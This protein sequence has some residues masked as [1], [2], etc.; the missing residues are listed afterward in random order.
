M[1]SFK[2]I[3]SRLVLAVLLAGSA[4][5]ASAKSILV[6][7]PHP[8]DETMVS[9]GRTRA[10]VLAGDTVHIVLS[11]NGDI[12]GRSAG[13]MREAESV[14]AAAVLGVPE[15]SVIFLGYGDQLLYNVWESASGT[16]VIR[17]VAGQTATYANRGLGG[18][19]FHSWRTGSPGPYNRN[20]VM[21]DFKA[22]ITAFQPDE[23]YT[24]SYWDNHGDHAA[25]AFFIN[26]ALIA[27]KQQGLDIRTRVFQSM[28]WPPDTGNNCYANWP[29][30]GSGALPYPPYPVPPCVVPGTT[31]DWNAVQRFAVPP[32][33]QRPDSATNLKWQALAAYPSQ[34]NDFLSSFVRE[35]EFFWR[36]DYGTN[37]SALAQVSASTDFPDGEGAMAHAIDGYADL[38]HEWKSQ[39][40]NGA[41]IQLNWSSPVRTAQINLYDRLDVNDNVRAGTLS[42]SDGSTMSVGA[43]PTGGKPLSVTFSPRVVSWVRFTI[44]QAVGNTAGLAEFEVLGVPASRTD[45]VAPHI[46]TGPLPA[47]ATIDSSQTLALS[48]NAWD[49][50]GD[51]LAYSWSADGGS[52]AGNGPSA[53]YT[54]PA[55]S[56]TTLFTVS[57]EISDGRGGVTGNSA[58][59]TVT[60]GR[61]AGLNLSPAS[62]TAGL[63]ST[64]TVLLSSAAP[65]GGTVVP[66]SSSNTAAAQAP[67][68]VTVSAGASSATFTISTSPVSATTQVVITAT[69]GGQN[70]TANLTVTPAGPTGLTLVPA[71]AIG[72][73]NVQATV[74]VSTA[75]PPGGQVLDLAASNPSLVSMPATV[76]VPAGSTTASF[77]IATSPVASAQTLSVTA[78]NAGV[79]VSATLTLNPL[80]LTGLSLNPASVAGGVS[81]QGT[82]TM[83]GPAYDSSAVV[84]LS[85]SNGAASV[86]ASV[87][88]AAGSSTA[89]F[90]ATTVS[91]GAS[92]SSTIT[93]T[94][95]GT[96]RTAVLTVNPPALSAVSLSPATVTAGA[97]STGT[98]TLTGPAPAAGLPVALSSNTPAA[99]S[100]PA[101][102]TVP[103]GTSSATFP[104]TTYPVTAKK[105]VTISAV[106]AGVT[107]TATL[108]VNTLTVSTI[109]LAPTSLIG[110]LASIATV[111]MSGAVPDPGAQIALSSGTAAAQVPASV[112]IPA[113][114]TTAT[115]TVTTSAVA[116]STSAVISATYG[117]TKTATLTVKP[118]A[119]SKL[120]LAPT[121]LVGGATSTATITLTGPAPQ[122]GFAVSTASN[123][124]AAVVPETVV[125]PEGALTADFAVATSA[126]AAVTSVSISSTAGT[127]T[128]SATLVITPR[129]AVSSIVLSPASVGSGGASVA[130]VT[131][132]APAP[133]GGLSVT[134]RSSNT[135][136]A[137]VPASVLVPEGATSATFSVLAKTVTVSS[138]ASI[139]AAAGG[140]TKSATLTVTP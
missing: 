91:V 134:T 75:A 18:T 86:P 135:A 38:S 87:T 116:A 103:G 17:S 63:T 70:K 111:T 24:V 129:T 122:G 26:E 14:A 90:T 97:G 34:F 136:V 132:N 50:D 35:D 60:P 44:D 49:L 53:V 32:E 112:T 128:K 114:A 29:P 96:S 58:F 89:T 79:T 7:G 1:T 67:A 93:A 33:M 80:L 61:A 5:P 47:V 82:V 68:S 121:S 15:Q 3:A 20:T 120:A 94:F 104:I 113:G 41:W 27:L 130:T 25:T 21:D 40:L 16:Q 36:F 2:K 43:L 98:V 23:I 59:V 12:D 118:P 108:T 101:T 22:L 52:L 37:L 11:T 102:V 117:N 139:S 51:P 83:N 95:G 30:A 74:T 115:F 73:S 133:A 54:P 78:S 57:V 100:V 69:I 131:I 13:L 46:I 123:N 84:L 45:D 8:D 88:V 109:K 48:V 31:L 125:V 10:A 66:L 138:T 119:L 65:T 39:E 106:L 85:S 56:Q 4:L 77:S 55:V 124:A 19:D 76:T 9:G 6:I 28:V 126:V 71:S 81:S 64:G 72:G 140:V 127:V 42:F 105:T 110:G 107:K 92:T 137:T 99:A 62:V